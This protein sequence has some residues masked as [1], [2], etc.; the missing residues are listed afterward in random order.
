MTRYGITEDYE[1][2]ATHKRKRLML[3]SGS[4]MSDYEGEALSLPK[5]DGYMANLGYGDKVR[6]T[7]PVE[8]TD[9]NYQEQDKAFNDA[10]NK[11]RLEYLRSQIDAERISTYEVV[12]LQSLVEYI[13]SGDVQLLEWAGVPEFGEDDD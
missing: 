5:G 4:F 9:A 6:V 10:L 11:Q 8:R 12:E 7:A 13:D 3:W 2:N 1:Y